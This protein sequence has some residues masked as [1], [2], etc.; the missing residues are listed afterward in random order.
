MLLKALRISN[1][2]PLLNLAGV[3][4]PITCCLTLNFTTMTLAEFKSQNNISTLSFYK[5]KSTN[6]YVAGFGQDMV[7]ITTENFDKA[8]PCFVY[9]NPKDTEGKSFILSNSEPRAADFTLQWSL[10]TL[11]GIRVLNVKYYIL[12]LKLLLRKV[13]VLL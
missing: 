1:Q 13:E 4:T 5:S 9:D 12:H 8:K 7:L 11:R 2:P 6:R 3:A 10:L